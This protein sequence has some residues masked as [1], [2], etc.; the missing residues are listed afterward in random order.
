[1]G[2]TLG[3]VSVTLL[4]NVQQFLTG[5]KTA[6]TNISAIEKQGLTANQ[7]LSSSFGSLFKTVGGGLLVFG[8]LKK[9]IYD[10]VQ[11]YFQSIDANKRLLAAVDGNIEKF[12]ELE[13][14]A[15]RLQSI[16]IYSD[17]TIKDG[18]TFLAMQDRINELEWQNAQLEEYKY[19]YDALLQDNIDH[20]VRMTGN[21][22]KLF[23]TPGVVEAFQQ[24]KDVAASS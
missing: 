16:T 4:M 13:A 19:K 20:S 21:M 22:L 23:M 12:K 8:L 1:M 14:Q 17:E 2:T 5:S 7:K 9:G 11:A 3:E 6:Q 15:N 10:S 18:Q 24:N